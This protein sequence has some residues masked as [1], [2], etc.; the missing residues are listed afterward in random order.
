MA[1]ID[2]LV[3]LVERLVDIMRI[4]FLF[5]LNYRQTVDQ[6]GG[7]EATVLLS[8]YFCRTVD[9]AHYLI[10]RIPRSYLL[11]IENSQKR[12]TTVV[13]IDLDLRNAVE[14][15]KELACL[16]RRLDVRDDFDHLIKLND[17]ERV[18]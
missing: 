1:L 11:L 13:Q 12:M 9:L 16:I 2:I 14:A 4:A 5:N 17:A 18:V 10:D 15:I 6:E 8:R 7:I 3:H